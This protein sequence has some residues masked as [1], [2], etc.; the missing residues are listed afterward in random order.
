MFMEHYVSAADRIRAEKRKRS[1]E[2]NDA[3]VLHAIRQLVRVNRTLVTLQEI[4]SL[5]RK[6]NRLVSQAISRLKSKDVLI[7]KGQRPLLYVAKWDESLCTTERCWISPNMTDAL[8]AVYFLSANR[9]FPPDTKDVAKCL[10]WTIQIT[11]RVIQQL[12]DLELIR[13]TGRNPYRLLPTFNASLSMHSDAVLNDDRL[14][15]DVQAELV[16]AIYNMTLGNITAPDARSLSRKTGISL[17]VVNASLKVLD[18]AQIIYRD[19][20]C[21]PFQIYLH[22]GQGCDEIAAP[23]SARKFE[24]LNI[25]DGETVQALW[26]ATAEK[27]RPVS[28]SE[29][30]TAFDGDE[31]RVVNRLHGLEKHG[32]LLRTEKVKAKF[33]VNLDI[34]GNVVAD[35]EHVDIS[36]RR[37]TLKQ[38]EILNYLRCHITKYGDSPTF[39]E[40]QSVT[41]RHWRS[42]GTL[43]Q[44]GLI[45]V[46]E[47]AT[48]NQYRIM[49]GNGMDDI[50]GDLPRCTTGHY[51]VYQGVLAVIR[52]RR[53]E[54][55]LT[56]AQILQ[57][58]SRECYASIDEVAAKCQ[59]PVDEVTQYVR[60]MRRLGI[61]YS[62][63]SNRY[64]LNKHFITVARCI[65]DLEI[66]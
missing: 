16:Q 17:S 2:A 10:N 51:Q 20:S 40:L 22:E 18:D 36:A 1:E 44:K 38:A 21:N 33:A 6:S 46:D 66:Q 14:I 37:I 63:Y 35:S 27:Q 3:L 15:T 53:G 48:T 26:N 64:S 62:V 28:I 54:P 52:E 30:A 59:L 45:R 25:R 9:N 32:L 55:E 13:Y 60:V 47:T 4:M 7:V 58:K 42:I 50:A 61:F 11:Y 19:R 39:R 49:H 24:R 5:T 34:P 29:L 8:Q 31:G 43:V 12:C 23:V 57:P 41:G 56:I 65:P